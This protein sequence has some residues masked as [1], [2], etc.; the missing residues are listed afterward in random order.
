MVVSALIGGAGAL[1]GGAIAAGGAKSAAKTQANAAQNIENQQLQAGQ[2]AAALMKPYEGMG[3]TAINE[4]TSKLPY[5]TTPYSPTM[6]Q[7]EQTPGYEFTLGQGL[8]SVQNAAAAKGLGIS[9]AALK[10]AAQYATGLAQNT[11]GQNAG[12]YQQNQ[13]QIGNLLTSMVGQGEQ[14]AGAA[15]GMQVGQSNAAA[16]TGLTGAGAAAA[17]QVGATNALSGGLTG[18]ANTMAQMGI[19]NAM[20]AQNG[21]GGG[22]GS[23]LMNGLGSFH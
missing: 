16:N 21:R 4:L 15:G 17:G 11:Y 18:A 3:Q 1:L 14:A 20:M 7:L 23:L 19:L 9:G 5:L 2:Q 13:Q 8:K 10:G 22:T 12:I 6:A